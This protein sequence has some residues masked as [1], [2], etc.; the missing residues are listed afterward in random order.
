MTDGGA[1]GSLR[2]IVRSSVADVRYVP[3][4]ASLSPSA[5]IVQSSRPLK[6]TFLLLLPGQGIM[7]GSCVV[8]VAYAS[9]TPKRRQH[10]LELDC[11]YLVHAREPEYD[12]RDTKRETQLEYE[13]KGGN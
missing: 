3:S 5:G 1:N 7:V 9:S 13:G 12:N 6:F 2:T 11:R 8:V 4:G 10:S